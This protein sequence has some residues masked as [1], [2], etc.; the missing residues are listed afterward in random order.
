MASTNT[1]SNPLRRAHRNTAGFTLVELSVSGAI[2]LFMIAGILTTYIVASRG[3]MAISNYWEIHHDGRT[4]VDQFAADM[5]GVYHINSFNTNGPVSVRI[6]T[7]F[8]TYGGVTSYKTVTYSYSNAALYR[9]DSSTGRT[10]MLATNIYSLKFQL[11]NRVGTPETVLANAK[12]ISLELFLRKY[13]AGQAQTEDFLSARLD[14][15]NK[16]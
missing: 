3:F 8:S 2:G 5:R 15:R 7:S 14:M 12:A 1:S 10:A 4:S 16:P 6:P 11:Y 13:T 9:A